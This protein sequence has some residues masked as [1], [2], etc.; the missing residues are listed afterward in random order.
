MLQRHSYLLW[1]HLFKYTYVLAAGGNKS[2]F[3][4]MC[5]GEWLH[6]LC[7]QNSIY[8]LYLQTWYPPSFKDIHLL[9]IPSVKFLGL[10]FASKQ[11]WEPHLWQFS[12]NCEKA[13]NIS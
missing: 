3:F 12:L 7:H 8:M 10:I 9:L 2:F 4:S 1:A 11:F 13:L 5:F 6:I